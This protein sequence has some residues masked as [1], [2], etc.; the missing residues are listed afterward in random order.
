MT[1]YGWTY[2]RSCHA[3]IFWLKNEKTGK[4]APIDAAPSQDGNIEIE[5]GKGIYRVVGKAPGRHTSHFVTCPAAGVWKRHGGNGMRGP[6]PTER[7]TK[8]GE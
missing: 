2:C 5:A 8:K 3:K 6:R 7:S 4:L 1:L